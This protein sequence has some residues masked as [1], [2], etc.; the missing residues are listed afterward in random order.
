MKVQQFQPCSKI[1]N[2][3]HNLYMY[4]DN[5]QLGNEVECTQIRHLE[6]AST[7]LVPPS[8]VP[9]LQRPERRQ[10]MHDTGRRYNPD[11]KES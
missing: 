10:G 7:F 6:R 9:Y 11:M 1:V 3:D 2:R 5:R 4:G 8:A